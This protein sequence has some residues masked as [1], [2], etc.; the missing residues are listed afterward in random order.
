VIG[1]ELTFFLVFS[2]AVFL[3]LSLGLTVTAVLSKRRL[4]RRI[5]PRI[6]LESM[7]H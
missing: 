5:H 4:R 3:T 7:Q 2:F 1:I 6:R